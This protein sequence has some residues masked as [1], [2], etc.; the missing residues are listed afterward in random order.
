M[1]Y[2]VQLFKNIYDPGSGV[3]Y[4][5]R[6]LIQNSNPT[7]ATVTITFTTSTG[8]A[9]VH[10]GIAIPPGGSYSD[11]IDSDPALS[12]LGTFFGIG[13][14]TSTQ[15]V[16]AVV[17][18]RATGV[19]INNSGLTNLRAGTALYLTQLLKGIYDSSTVMLTLYLASGALQRTVSVSPTYPNF[20]FDFTLTP[21][22]SLRGRGSNLRRPGCHV[23]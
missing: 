1:C 20:T 4:N 10:S 2:S 12:G 16:A 19:L 9:Y 7:A 11:P 17:R 5:S 21:T 23:T 18:H 22:L 14:V 3:T 13:R 15:P 8:Q 6:L